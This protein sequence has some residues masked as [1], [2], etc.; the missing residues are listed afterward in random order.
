M[1][2]CE[3]E[4]WTRWSPAVP[5]NLCSVLLWSWASCFASLH[6]ERY[7]GCICSYI[8]RFSTSVKCNYRYSFCRLEISSSVTVLVIVVPYIFLLSHFKEIN[9]FAILI[10]IP[11]TRKPTKLRKP[12]S[13]THQCL[14]FA[15]VQTSTEGLLLTFSWALSCFYELKYHSKSI[16]LDLF[17]ELITTLL[18]DITLLKVLVEKQSVAMCTGMTKAEYL[19]LSWSVYIE[20]RKVS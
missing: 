12:P 19:Q 14:L 11:L 8:M 5:C 2:L 6:I 18:L 15:Q 10:S 1:A 7:L 16:D 4:A 13:L 9:S 20:Q 17:E 3:Q